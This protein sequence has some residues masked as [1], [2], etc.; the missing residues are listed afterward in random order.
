MNIFNPEKTI[1]FVFFCLCC[2]EF[3][4]IGHSFFCTVFQVLRSYLL[5]SLLTDFFDDF[6]FSRRYQRKKFDDFSAENSFSSQ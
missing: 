5:L 2:S 6:V 3:Y 1:I 4:V